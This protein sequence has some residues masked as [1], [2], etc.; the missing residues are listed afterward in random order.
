MN[1]RKINKNILP[2]FIN[3]NNQNIS[4]VKFNLYDIAKIRPSK[5][6]K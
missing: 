2:F 4:D 6:R 5:N 3:F 1:R